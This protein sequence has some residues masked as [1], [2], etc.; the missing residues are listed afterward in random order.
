M[1]AARN[2]YLFYV[3]GVDRLFKGDFYV[4]AQFIQ[5]IIFD[6]G[7]EYL[8]DEFQ[9]GVSLYTY[10][11]FELF[12]RKIV[13]EVRALYEINGNGFFITPKVTYKWSDTLEISLGMNIFEGDRDTIFGYF[14]DNDQV[15]FEAKYIF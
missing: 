2:N 13:P 5:K 12:N 14:T 6:Y 1:E 10:K 9:S 15:F 11:E 8:E 4:N 7:R 3:V